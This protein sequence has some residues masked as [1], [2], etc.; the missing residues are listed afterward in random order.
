M[1]EL[2]QAHLSS[3][4]S[5]I[6]RGIL[7]GPQIGDPDN[8][9]DPTLIAVGIDGSVTLIQPSGPVK[10]VM[11]DRVKKILSSYGP[12]SRLLLESINRSLYAIDFRF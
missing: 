3:P 1:K 7:R 11:F 6:R 10:P 9:K 2:S 8:V 12:F 4:I 5:R